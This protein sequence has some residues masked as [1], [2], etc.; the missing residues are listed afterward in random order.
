MAMSKKTADKRAGSVLSAIFKPS[1]E[2][3]Q[4]AAKLASKSCDKNTKGSKKACSKAGKVVG[5]KVTGPK[6]NPKPGC[7]FYSKIK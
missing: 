3:K 4:A 1:K 2:C 7:K 5:S 6:S